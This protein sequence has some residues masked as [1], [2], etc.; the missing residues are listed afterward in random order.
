MPIQVAAN[1]SKRLDLSIQTFREDIV[2]RNFTLYLDV[3]N[4]VH[5]IR[6]DFESQAVLASG[7]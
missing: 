5:E 2:K 6:L 4:A 1:S 3:Q 7:E